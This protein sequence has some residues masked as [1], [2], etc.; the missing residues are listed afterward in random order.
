MT[1]LGMLAWALFGVF[2]I[3]IC[4]LLINAVFSGEKALTQADYCARAERLKAEGDPAP[5]G[6]SELRDAQAKCA[7]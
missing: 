3:G 4:W 2:W 6:F 7:G 1:R 5:F